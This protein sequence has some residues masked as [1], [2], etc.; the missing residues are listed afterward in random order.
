MDRDLSW[1]LAHRLLRLHWQ[2]A[3]LPQTFQI[4]DSDDQLR[5]IK[6]IQKELNIDNTNFPPRQTQ[7]YINNQKDEGIRFECLPA[8]KDRSEKYL[9][10]IYKHYEQQCEQLGLVDF[11]ELLLRSKELFDN[12]KEL[13]EHYQNRFKHIL[14]DEF[15][16]T[17]TLQY[18][19]LKSLHNNH[20]FFTMVGDD[21]QSIYGW[22]GAKVENIQKFCD[23]YPNS[24]TVRLEQ[25]Y[26]ST[27]N[28]LD[29]ANALISKNQNRPR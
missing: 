13:V 7:Y 8:T 9:Q 29:A 4:C 20:N 22:R 11:A 19:W 16:D 5:I 23:D 28:I 17:N 15:Q 6:R 1:C 25:N 18:Q 3:G 27:A 2:L 21:D 10:E 26:R 24:K 12:N 14:V